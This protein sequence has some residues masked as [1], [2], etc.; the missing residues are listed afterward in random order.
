MCFINTN[1]ISSHYCKLLGVHIESTDGLQIFKNKLNN[2][3]EIKFVVPQGTVLGHI[4]F[5]LFVNGILVSKSCGNIIKLSYGDN[6]AVASIGNNCQISREKI[7]NNQSVDWL[8][9]LFT[10]KITKT[11]F[12]SFT[13]QSH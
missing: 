10:I 8:Q 3:M 12:V 7:S 6:T 2:A 5:I 1:I 9:Y 11:E 13:A 4:F